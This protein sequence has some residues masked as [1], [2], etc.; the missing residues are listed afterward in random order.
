MFI[1]KQF[2]FV[3]QSNSSNLSTA[4]RYVVDLAFTTAEAVAGLGKPCAVQPCPSGTVGEKLHLKQDQRF[5][6][7][8][9][10][11]DHISSA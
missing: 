4:K 9:L 7:T 1:M 11:Q 8:A 10:D 6:L 3:K 2:G 5:D